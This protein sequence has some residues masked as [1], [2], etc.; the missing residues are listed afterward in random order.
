MSTHDPDSAVPQKGRRHFMAAAAGMGAAVAGLL[1]RAPASAEALAASAA[2]P[3][4]V[5]G[6]GYRE[7]E[8]IRK[9]YRC[10]RYW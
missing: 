9:Y 5:A 3:E 1:G 8:H 7:S 6:G 2:P 10:A 4:P